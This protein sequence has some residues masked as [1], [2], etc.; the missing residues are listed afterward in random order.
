MFYFKIQTH[1]K[2]AEIVLDSIGCSCAINGASN[3][4]LSS[5][6]GSEGKTPDTE[7]V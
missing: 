7:N 1:V 2:S 4:L 6:S 3:A 5:K